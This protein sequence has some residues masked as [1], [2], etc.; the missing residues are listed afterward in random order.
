M[1]RGH[2]KRK[3]RKDGMECSSERWC[4]RRPEETVR[5]SRVE[6][7]SMQEVVAVVN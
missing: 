1:F 7:W 6:S 4:S 3:P 5:D 2:N